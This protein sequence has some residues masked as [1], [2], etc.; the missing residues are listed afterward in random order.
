MRLLLCVFLFLC[1]GSGALTNGNFSAG[2]SGWTVDAPNVVVAVI[3]GDTLRMGNVL[4]DADATLNNTATLSQTFTMPGVCGENYTMH[5]DVFGAT[6]DFTQ[7]NDYVA[8][9]IM[10]EST[11][12]LPLF[13]TLFGFNNAEPPTYFMPFAYPLCPTLN[14]YLNQPLT[15]RF[16]LHE[17]GN[18]RATSLSMKNVRIE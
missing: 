7:Q 10:H 6:R 3:N 18:G 12:V 1:V 15:L 2:L 11:V 9:Y 17:N 14:A 5:V 13:E 8:A 4:V 16:V